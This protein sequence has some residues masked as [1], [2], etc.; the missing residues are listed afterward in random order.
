VVEA[1]LSVCVC[2]L[3][4]VDAITVDKTRPVNGLLILVD[5]A[6]TFTRNS[7]RLPGWTE[8]A[9]WTERRGDRAVID[10]QSVDH[11]ELGDWTEP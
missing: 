4:N 3:F 10:S 8:A 7:S 11:A 1:R 9:A 6:R 5:L 2:P